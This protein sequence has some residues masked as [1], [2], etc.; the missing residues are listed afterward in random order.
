MPTR[1][2]FESDYIAKKARR[3]AFR[4]RRRRRR[5]IIRF[6]ILLVTLFAFFCIFFTWCIF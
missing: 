4:R 6:G 1:T 2:N 5:V 3:N